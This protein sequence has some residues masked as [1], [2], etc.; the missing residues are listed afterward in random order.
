MIKL[1]QSALVLL[2]LTSMTCSASLMITPLRASFFDTKRSDEIILVNNSEE[3]NSYRLEWVEQMALPQGGYRLLTAAEA[4]S[5]PTASKFLRYSPRQVTLKPGESQT[6]KLVLRKPNNLAP[7]EYRSHLRFR[8]IPKVLSPEAGINVYAIM[9]YAIP[10]IVKQGSQQA[11]VSLD[12]VTLGTLNGKPQLK[13][14]LNRSGP[15]SVIGNVQLFY[16]PAGG[17][18][19][20]EI[21]KYNDFSIYPELKQSQLTLINTGDMPTSLN[22]TLRLEYNGSQEWSGT[23]FASKEY[24]VTGGNI[25]PLN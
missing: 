25:R 2:M 17:S 18:N 16:K 22:G 24:Q 8:A 11:Q 1:I 13:V 15:S 12:E 21:A 10:V 3:V 19:Q 7:G 5:F 20:L 6:I 9:S 14:K 4:A 23:T